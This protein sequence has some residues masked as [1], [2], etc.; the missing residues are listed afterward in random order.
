[1]AV[2]DTGVAMVS[3]ETLSERACAPDQRR[4]V[5]RS[6]NHLGVRMVIVLV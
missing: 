2:V 4:S 6:K 3:A 1:M 5:A